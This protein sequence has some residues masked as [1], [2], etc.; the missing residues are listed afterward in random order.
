ME[1]DFTKMFEYIDK[2]AEEIKTKDKIAVE[3]SPQE[4]EL[5]LP[6]LQNLREEVERTHRI[7]GVVQEIKEKV[8][9]LLELTNRGS[10]VHTLRMII[11]ELPEE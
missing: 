9:E 6:M 8:Y 7:D 5:I 10:T 2:R 11:K 3:L 1:I 4:A